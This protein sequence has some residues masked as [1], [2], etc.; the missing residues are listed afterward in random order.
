[1][2]S[3]QR[4]IDEF[5][6][7]IGTKMCHKLK[8]NTSLDSFVNRYGDEIGKERYELFCKRQSYINTYP[9][10]VE[11]YGSKLARNEYIKRM[12]PW[13]NS[14]PEVYSKISQELFW[15]V[16]VALSDELQQK[17]KFA[18]LNEECKFVTNID[19]YIQVDF[20]CGNKIIEFNGDFWHANPKQY[21]KNEI[22]TH[23]NNHVIAEELWDNDKKRIDWLESHGYEVLIIW[24]SDYKKDKEQIINICI[25]F[26]NE[27]T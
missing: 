22:L 6:E 8:N 9:Y 12:G 7:V 21:K 13:L 23:P 17:I 14:K 11:R 27:T 3:L 4:Y 15:N 5:G 26:I 18:E 1:M 10:F 24:E 25:N 2:V 20:K 19:S 16:S